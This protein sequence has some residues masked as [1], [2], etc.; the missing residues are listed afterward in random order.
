MSD[1]I[2]YIQIHNEDITHGMDNR[3]LILFQ[4]LIGLFVNPGNPL[5]LALLWFVIIMVE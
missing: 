4:F 1:I 2:E 5:S 3:E